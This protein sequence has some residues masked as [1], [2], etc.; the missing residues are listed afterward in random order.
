MDLQYKLFDHQ[1]K[2]MNSTS[3]I[4]YMLC[5]RAAGKSYAASLLIAKTFLEGKKVIALAQTY[6][7]LNEVLFAEVIN[8]LDEMKV[9]YHF[10]RASMK[11]EYGSGVIYGAS[12]ENIE[13]VRGLSCIS[14]AVCDEAALS[15]NKLFPTLSPCLRGEGIIGYIR[16]LSTPR[17]GSWLNL[18]CKEH[19]DNI[20]IIHATTRDNK[21]ITE[22]QIKLMSDS[23]ANK[24]LLE[25]ELEGV[26]L[27]IDS[28]SSIIQLSEYAKTDSGKKGCCYMGIDLAGLGSDNNVFTVV[29]KYR[30]EEQ[31]SI[32]Q[33][34]TFELLSVYERLHSQYDIKNTFIDITG[35]TSCGLLDMI[36]AKKYK[37]TGINFAQKS[38]N[39]RYANARA[40]MY[41]E[42]SNA[43]KDGLYIEKDDIKTQLAY[44][45]IFVNNS[46]K[47]QLV[48]KE[49]I[50]DLIG[51]SPDESDSLAL[52]VYAMNHST[53]TKEE[54][55][56]KASDIAS[57]YL[58]FIGY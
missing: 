41:V 38:Y 48:K 29:S 23:I 37:V 21:F 40:E 32:N 31:I 3:P 15:P 55:V 25:Q 44:T 19:A 9:P 24:E 1:L 33:A 12:Y 39:E 47:F 35:S 58:H 53:V 30:I 27:D 17:R 45:T 18:Y 49:L 34:N 16:L 7:A 57:K 5:G 28:D 14:L 50:K 22:D 11:I 10:N 46:G 43:I 4:A 6:R 42:L 13:S 20:E 52:A 8:R 56:K 54:E 51:H 2:L 36:V 26:I